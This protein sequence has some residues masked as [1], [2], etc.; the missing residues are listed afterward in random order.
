MKP[1]LVRNV[2]L[3]LLTFCIF[4]L[5][6]RFTFIISFNGAFFFSSIPSSSFSLSSSSSYFSHSSNA[7]LNFR[8][9]LD[10]KF[11][12]SI[13][14]EF[15][16][17]GFLSPNSS[18]FS[19]SESHI[20][21]LKD[22]G[23]H[24]SFSLSSKISSPHLPFS[25]N[26]FDFQF[27]HEF[28]LP[29]SNS[30]LGFASEIERTLKPS[31]VLVIHTEIKDFYA[32]HSILELFDFC[33]L[34]RARDIPGP[35][36]LIP[37]IR[38]IILKKS[39]N[40]IRNFDSITDQCSVPRYKVRLIKDLE[41]LI[42]KEPL[43]P[44]IAL[45]RNL[46]NVKYLTSMVDISFKSRYAYIDVGARSYGSSIGSWF[47]K[48]YPKQNKTFEIYAIEADKDFHDEYRAKK[49]VTLLPYAAWVKN[50]TLFFEINREPTKKNEEYR[51][52]G[53][54]QPVQSSSNFMVNVDKIKGF[55]FA[56]WL[57][58]E[59]KEKDFVIMKMDVEG[60]EFHLIPRLIETGAIC[61]IDE[62]FLEC[63]YNRWQK[64]CPGIRSPKYEKTYDQC[65]NLFSSLRKRG[66]VVHQWW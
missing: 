32:F 17:N 30:L 54:I 8:T 37:S 59:F 5:L 21:A 53:R 40:P 1:N 26:S 16:F 39:I 48:R 14:Q 51:G 25:N 7:L 15:I 35:N 22:L 63:H 34:I 50:E 60:A 3:R 58:S 41:P 55:D 9:S 56:E 49:G 2:F 31:G 66:V 12:T 11:Y 43:K 6:L 20:I 28:N 18:A 47:R 64:C 23:I 42:E 29:S 52:M 57:K 27:F 38:E 19:L 13:F 4:L 10:Y 33:K 65:L 46:R 61:L 24:H 45:K 62:I 44:W 36:A